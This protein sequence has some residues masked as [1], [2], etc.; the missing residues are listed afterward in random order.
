MQGNASRPAGRQGKGP[1]TQAPSPDG[2][3]R[4]FPYFTTFYRVE[5]SCPFLTTNTL[6]FSAKINCPE[7]NEKFESNNSRSFF[8]VPP[9]AQ[10]PRLGPWYQNPAC[11]PLSISG[12]GEESESPRRFSGITGH[13]CKRKPE[14]FLTPLLPFPH[15]GFTLRDCG[16]P[17][18]SVCRSG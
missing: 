12:A 8:Y 11:N 13:P 6:F 9:K 10:Q 5:C 1:A 4:W 15:P 18:G 16:S 17:R 3:R 14:G 2:G 7:N